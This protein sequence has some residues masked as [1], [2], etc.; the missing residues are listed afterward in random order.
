VIEDI[1]R[2]IG[3]QIRV[4]RRKLK[5]KQELLASKLAISRG[6]LANIEIGNQRVLV[7]QLY[8]FAAELKLSPTDLL[9]P[10]PA[11]QT[12]VEQSDIP[13]PS[14]LNSQQAKQVTSLLSQVKT[15]QNPKKEEHHVKNN[16]R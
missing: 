8:R 11:D 12:D 9:P 6:S 10:M 2:H 13:L 3:A 16:K 4:K 7:H 14:H 15:S 1:Y 5:W